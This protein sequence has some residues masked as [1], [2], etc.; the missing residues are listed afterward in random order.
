MGG[1]VEV[2]AVISKKRKNKG[3]RNMETGK[4]KQH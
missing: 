1:T 4:S 2:T 3:Q